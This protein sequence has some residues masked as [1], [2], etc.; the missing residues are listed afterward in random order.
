MTDFKPRI[1][2]GCLP[3]IAI[4]LIVIILVVTSILSV[5]DL[6]FNLAWGH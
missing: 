4:V 1:P 5:F 3:K 6:G 2:G